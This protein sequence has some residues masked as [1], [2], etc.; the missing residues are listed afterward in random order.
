MHHE[1]N[2][3][4]AIKLASGRPSAVRLGDATETEALIR[5]DSGSLKAVFGSVRG[6]FAVL[7]DTHSE[8]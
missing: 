4:L 6:Q 7:L 5:S 3:D 2:A 1:I 8:Q